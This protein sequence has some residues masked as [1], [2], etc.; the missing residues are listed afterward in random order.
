FCA[1]NSSTYTIPTFTATSVCGSVN[2]SYS[3][4]GA[5]TRSG[6]TNNASGNFGIGTSTIVWS[7]SDAAG[8]TSTCQT[9][10]V[11]NANP[12]VTIPDAYALNSGVVANTVYPGYVPASS[13]TIVANASAG[14]NN[15]SWSN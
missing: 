7:A 3:I 12:S 10:V 4:T 6:N 14:V 9:T 13:I 15:Y 1:N 5:T 2:Y 8:N 11:V